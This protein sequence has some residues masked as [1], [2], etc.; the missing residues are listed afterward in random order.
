MS[1]RRLTVIGG[2]PGGYSAAFAA[3]RAGLEVTL[4]EAGSIGGT[5]LNSGCIPTKTLKALADALELTARLAEFGLS[6][7]AAV[8]D[9]AAVMNRKNKVMATLRGGLEKSCDNLKISRISGLGRIVN[10]QL[11]EVTAPDGGKHEVRGDKVIIATGSKPLELPGLAFDHKYILSSDDALNLTEIPQR[12]LIVGG[13]VIGCELA[14][15]FQAFGSEVAIV[16]GQDRLLPLPS[17]DAEISQ[18]LQRELKKRK[19]AFHLGRTVK[20]ACVESGAV[21]ARLAPSPFSANPPKGDLEAEADAVLV[22]VGRVPCTGGLGLAEAGVKVDAR[23]WIT[24]DE[25]LNTSV[26]GVYAVGDVLG[27]QKGMLAHVAAMEGACAAANC[28]GKGRKMD[29][30]LIPSGVFTTPEIGCVGLSEAQA[31]EQGINF[32]SNTFQMRQL[33]KMQAMGELGG[34]CKIIADA[35]SGGIIGAHI[36]GPHATD[37][38]AEA[39]LAIK[40]KTR[41]SDLVEIMHAHP[42]LAEGIFEAAMGL[43]EQKTD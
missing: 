23:G 36:A 20:D 11:V 7:S 13:G 30:S 37:L 32:A 4:A 12:L 27:P 9:M 21:Q 35:S 38:L 1:S 2:G 41:A 16:E 18:L 34:I 22:T 29:Y 17:I 15:I 43:V 5:C 10:A 6:G 3:A 14:F 26:P 40:T 31:K 25:C 8:P 42:T 24:A 39:V 33:G 28:L 19:I